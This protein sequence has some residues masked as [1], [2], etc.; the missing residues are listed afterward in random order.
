VGFVLPVQRWQALDASRRWITEPWSTR[1][2]RLFV[3][4]GESPVGYRLP[5][6]SLPYVPPTRYP[7]V[8]PIDPFESRDELPEPDE[9]RQPFLTGGWTRGRDHEQAQAGAVQFDDE[10]N[11]I[12]VR[13]AL[14]ATGA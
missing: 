4:P 3:V 1:G 2:K 8:V 5:L 12:A 13:T 11:A 7:Q 14:V 6:P 9:R 10:K